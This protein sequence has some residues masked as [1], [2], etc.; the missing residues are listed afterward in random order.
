LSISTL[1]IGGVVAYS[2]NQRTSEFGL[3]MAL[4]AQRRDVLTMVL[5]EGLYL[6]GAGLALGV[7]MATLFTRSIHDL[8]FGVGEYDPLTMILVALV[9]LAVTVGACFFPARRAASVDPIR[10]LR[11]S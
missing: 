9:L 11:C 5:R 8:L 3:L 1:G 4:G 10:A 7:I 2:V 6:V